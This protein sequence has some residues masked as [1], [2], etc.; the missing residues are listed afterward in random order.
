MTA[1]MS[2]PTECGVAD[3]V[4][5]PARLEALRCLCLLDTPAE[6]G[7]DRHTRLATRTLHVPVSLV[8]LVDA[9]RQFFKSLVGLAEPW[10]S[11]RQTPLSH[12]FCQYTVALGAPLIVE[13]AR[14]HPVLR[15]NL[16]IPDLGVVAYAGIPLVRD[17]GYVLG[18]FCAIDTKPHAWSEAEVAILTDLAGCVMAE[19]ELRVVAREAEAANRAKSEFLAMM[20]HELRTPLNAIIGFGELLRDGVIDAE[21]D[22]QQAL[23]DIQESGEHLLALIN[24]ILDLAKIE[25]G[26][27]ELDC[28]ETDLAALFASTVTLVRERAAV[29]GLHLTADTGDVGAVVADT[30][31][32]KQILFNLTTNAIKFTPAGGSVRIAARE[33]A[34]GIEI[35]VADTGIGISE[36]DQGRLFKEFV[37]VDG[38]LTRRHEGTGLGLALTRRLVELHGG[39]IAVQSVVGEGTTFTVWLPVIQR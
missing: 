18:S 20:S 21:E 6:E 31:K 14:I 33:V 1:T 29:R 3:A 26:R 16:A 15:T 9:G 5:D 2:I 36:A 19:I 23:Q 37:Q 27:M 13:D 25:A 8:S 12:S 7:F 38:S 17:D 32:L 24:D 28:T 34:G 22:R 10:A 35:V 11:A 39:R 30:R 4:L